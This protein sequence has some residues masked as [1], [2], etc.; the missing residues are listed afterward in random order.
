MCGTAIPHTPPLSGTFYRLLLAVF[1][2]QMFMFWKLN[3]H[4]H[5][6]VVFRGEALGGSED[7]KGPEGASVKARVAFQEEEGTRASRPALPLHRT[8]PRDQEA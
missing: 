4:T 1:G 2:P 7:G 3:L 8:L 6:F 5:K